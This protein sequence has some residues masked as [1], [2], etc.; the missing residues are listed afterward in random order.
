MQE[1]YPLYDGFCSSFLGFGTVASM[2]NGKVNGRA[3]IDDVE[4]RAGSTSCS[5]LCGSKD[6]PECLS[7][8]VMT[9]LQ[10]PL[11]TGV[12]RYGLWGERMIVFWYDNSFGRQ[13]IKLGPWCIA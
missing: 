2:R 7:F 11:N 13:E 1:A 5:P 6:L 8:V 9:I 4:S 3:I 10:S 12:R